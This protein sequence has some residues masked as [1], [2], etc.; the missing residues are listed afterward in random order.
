MHIE[1]NTATIVSA[2]FTRN[3]VFKDYQQNVIF[4]I[5]TNKYVEL[6]KSV[7]ADRILRLKKK[8]KKRMRNAR[9]FDLKP[10]VLFNHDSL[11]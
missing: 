9:E 3:I 4:D 2:E 11:V 10:R 7:S 6:C 5:Q 8:K 1:K